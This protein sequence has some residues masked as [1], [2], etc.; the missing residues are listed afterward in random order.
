[1]RAG[2]VHVEPA[3]SQEVNMDL[4]YR[5]W[6]PWSRLEGWRYGG[7]EFPDLAPGMPAE[8]ASRVVTGRGSIDCSSLTA[9]CIL[10]AYPRAHLAHPGL[11]ADLQVQDHTRPWSPIEGLERAG[12]GSRV[13]APTTHGAWYL[14]QTWSRLDNGR[15]VGR[16]EAERRG[17]KPST[18]HARLALGLPDGRLQVWESSQTAGGVREVVLPGIRGLGD[19]TRAAGLGP[20]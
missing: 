20:G 11:Y 6:R 9:Y 17:I 8:L 18:G 10:H 1:M 14:L 5:L 7:P 4:T 3:R 19:V 12:I 15:I 13:I 2:D 16:E